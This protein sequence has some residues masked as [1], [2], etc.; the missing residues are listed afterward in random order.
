MWLST[1]RSCGCHPPDHMVI[2]QQVMWSQKK[3]IVVVSIGNLDMSLSQ[4]GNV[5]VVSNRLRGCLQQV[6]WLSQTG[7]VVVSN[8]QCGGCLK[9]AMWWLSPTGYVVVSNR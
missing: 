6:T 4:T 1:N 2:I 5:V 8:R 7:N 3:G 9:Q